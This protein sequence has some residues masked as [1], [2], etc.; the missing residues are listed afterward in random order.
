[1]PPTDD[2]PA[3]PFAGP[4]TRLPAHVPIAVTYRGGHPEN[5]HHG[6]LAVVDAQGRLLASVGDVDSALFTR[7]SLKPF[8]A[9]PLIA[10]FADTLELDD[11]D[12]A[13]LCSSHN[14]EPMHV[15]RVARLL[16]RIGASEAALAC[17][18]HVPYFFG[19]TGQT[20]APGESFTRLHHNCSGKHT[21]MLLL[22]HALGQPLDGYL[23]PQ[24][25]VQQE[26]VRSVSHFSGVPA[27]RLVRG[28]DGCS[29]PNFALPLRALAQAFARLTLSAPDPVYGK[30]PQ[31]VARAMI[32]HPEL[33][34]GQGRNDLTLMDAGR[35][36]W[37][38]KVGADG[39]QAL[40]SFGRGVGIAAKCSDGQLVP[41][42]VALVS[43]LDQL[44]WLDAAGR[45]ALA[46]L[47]PPPMK[48]AADI[49]VGHMAAVL[50]LK[51]G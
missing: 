35:G 2:T 3:D 13:L 43:A 49:E 19:A 18:S 9:M 40:A 38:S 12:I 14:G 4:T 5:V 27:E 24:H 25:R 26:I 22:A 47:I 1:M 34:S 6:S 31:R 21:G 45:A 41:L 32:R 44:G 7:S 17:G 16:A 28:T 10:G 46:S 39:V 23:G 50:R 48:N 15:D 51:A 36:D 8:Q 29:A 33:V 42:M 11:A 30:A 37:V 20:P